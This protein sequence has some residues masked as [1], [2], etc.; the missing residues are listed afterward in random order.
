MFARCTLGMLLVATL[1]VAAACTTSA[2]PVVPA[3]E[4][5]IAQIHRSKCSS[6]HR[7]VEPATRTRAEIERALERHDK[8]VRLSHDDW[9]ALVDYL[10]P[11]GSSSQAKT[12]PDAEAR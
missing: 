7:L 6:C 12:T 9:R 8:R 10:A 5:R 4:T 2:R 1:G 3:S 11:S